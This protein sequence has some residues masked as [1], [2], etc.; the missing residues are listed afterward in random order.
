VAS[1]DVNEIDTL[2]ILWA[3]LK[4]MH[5]AIDGLDVMPELLKID[6]NRFRPYKSIPHE[7]V[8]GGDGII[9]C[10]SAAS[11]LAKTFRDDQMEVLAEKYP[12]YDWKNNKGYGTGK[13]LQAIREF[14][15]TPFHRRSF[16]PVS[17]LRFDI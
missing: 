17:Q 6:G 4:A 12:E 8:I 5:K 2:N 3:S 14:G 16:K 15:C 11:I 1:C 7:C 13:H 10:I 9:D